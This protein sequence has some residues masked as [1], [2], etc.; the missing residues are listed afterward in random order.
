MIFISTCP[1]AGIFP[2]DGMYKIGLDELIFYTPEPIF[3]S[4]KST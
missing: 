3:Y 4:T 1:F 2:H